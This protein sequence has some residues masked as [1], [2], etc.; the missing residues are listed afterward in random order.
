M[1]LSSVS[2]SYV[3]LAMFEWSWHHLQIHSTSKAWQCFSQ[4]RAEVA[5]LRK[6]LHPPDRRRGRSSTPHRRSTIPAFSLNLHQICAGTTLVL[7]MLP[8]NA[9]HHVPKVLLTAT[10][11]AGQI[12]TSRL[13]FISDHTSGLRFLVDTG[14]EISVIPPS[15]T[16][17]LFHPDALVLQ[18]ANDTLILTFGK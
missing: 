5:N 9:D 13:F 4:L 15:C 14:A 10:G 2:C 16:D 1:D 8:E 11:V 18:A 17:R 7:V 6:M 3:C 12:H